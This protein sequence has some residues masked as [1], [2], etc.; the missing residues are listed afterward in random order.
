MESA[1]GKEDDD[2]LKELLKRNK[3]LERHIRF[4][5]RIK[6]GEIDPVRAAKLIDKYCANLDEE[7]KKELKQLL[8]IDEAII[9]KENEE[10]KENEEVTI[11]PSNIEEMTQSASLEGIK[12]ETGSIRKEIENQRTTTNEI[13][14]QTNDDEDERT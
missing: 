13:G 11:K 2:K 4:F 12:E 5:E 9:G 10:Q 8:K 6:N 7:Y 3:H 14:E 1:E